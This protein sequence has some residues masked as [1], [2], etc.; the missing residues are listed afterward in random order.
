MWKGL[1]NINFSHA[2]PSPPQ[3]ISPNP[4]KPPIQKTVTLRYFYFFMVKIEF[5]KKF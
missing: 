5:L 1:E 3:T 2:L 4:T